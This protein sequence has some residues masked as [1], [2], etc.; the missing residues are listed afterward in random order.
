[1]TLFCAAR[2]HI[3][4]VLL[5]NFTF[6]FLL[7]QLYDVANQWRRQ[8]LVRG[9]EGTKLHETFI[10][11]EMTRNNTL[12]K[13]HVA[14]TELPQLLLQNAQYKYVWRGNRTKSPSDFVQ[15]QS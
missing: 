10:A 15:L 2:R 9:G 14:A 8:D 7:F 11:H 6:S 5:S 13:D 1:M 4:N 3:V 12:N